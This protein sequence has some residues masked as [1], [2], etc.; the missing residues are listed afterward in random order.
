MGTYF[1]ARHVED[2]TMD[3]R[4]DPTPIFGFMAV[5][6]EPEPTFWPGNLVKAL[7]IAG[8]ILL[9]V[10]LCSIGAMLASSAFC[11]C[12]VGADAPAVGQQQRVTINTDSPYD[13]VSSCVTSEATG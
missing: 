2:Q 10:L 6:R 13:A 4:H 1:A 5:G 11:P 12:T 9:V 3:L 7:A 8:A